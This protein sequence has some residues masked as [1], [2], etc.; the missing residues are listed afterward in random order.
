MSLEL[1]IGRVFYIDDGL[2][3]FSVISE[4][5]IRFLPTEQLAKQTGLIRNGIVVIKNDHMIIFGKLFMWKK[6]PIPPPNCP[7]FT[8]SIKSNE[9]KIKEST[10]AICY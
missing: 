3:Q 7:S 2:A 10:T 9:K 6:N 1:A 5:T 4:A 8:P